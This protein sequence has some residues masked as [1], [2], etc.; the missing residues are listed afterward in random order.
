M[1][2]GVADG[3][4]KILIIA[5]YFP[6][7][8]LAAVHRSRLFAQHL[9]KFNWEPMVLSVQEKYYEEALDEHLVRLLDPN[10]RIE[11]TKAF[12][13]GRPRF[14]GDIGLRSFIQLYRR[15]KRLIRQEHFDFLYIPIP[16]FYTALLGRLLH[17]STGIPYG[18]DYI[19]PWVHRFPGSDKKFSRHWWSTM[20][21]RKLEPMAIK[22]ARLIT[23]VAEGYYKG[24]QERNPDLSATCIFGAMPYGGEVGDHEK[25]GELG[26]Q[27][28][29]IPE[30]SPKLRLAYAG[31]MLPKAYGPMEA[32]LRSMQANSTLFRDI[33]FHFIGTGK[34]PDDP[35]GFNIRPLAEKYGLWQTVIFEYP[36]RIPY[37]DVL[38][39]LQ[40][41]DGVFVL[42]S[43]EPHYTP[44][45]VYQGILSKK[46]ILALLHEASTASQVVAASGA[47]VVLTFNEHNFQEKIE[48]QFAGEFQAYRKFAANYQFSRIDMAAFSEYSAEKVTA[49]LAGLLEKTML[50]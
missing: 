3:M 33:E 36:K 8:N 42:G 29:L 17:A 23:G 41:V 44:S 49:V 14:I 6:P 48:T 12:P 15:A 30:T 38:I 39:H 31:A 45:K 2:G 9:P 20:L 50:Y 22:K 27:P 34:T 24:V 19:D 5:P 4:K 28:Y 37:L 40:A 16:P 46:P 10:L 11:R 21:A 26:L 13:I 7:S 1:A 25:I 43:I 47:G 18:I 32:M 35:E